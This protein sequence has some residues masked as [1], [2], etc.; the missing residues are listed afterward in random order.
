MVETGRGQKQTVV[1][2]IVV[3]DIEGIGA[4]GVF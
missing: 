4:K 3:V 2:W 1:C